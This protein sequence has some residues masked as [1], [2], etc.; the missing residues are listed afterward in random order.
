MVKAAD[1][2][3]SHSSGFLSGFMSLYLSTFRFNDP[4][5]DMPPLSVER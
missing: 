3:E 2:K 4:F 1:R 5:K